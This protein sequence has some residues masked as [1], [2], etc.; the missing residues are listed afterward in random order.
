MADCFWTDL[1]NTS[2]EPTPAPPAPATGDLYVTGSNADGA[3]GIPA[4][5]DLDVFT[6][7]TGE[8]VISDI[9]SGGGFHLL[10]K[11]GVV[12]GVGVSYDDQLNDG[13]F[14]TVNDY[15]DVYNGA[16][17]ISAGA[18]VSGILTTANNLIYY[19]GQSNKFDPPGGIEENGSWSSIHAGR[20][21][22]FAISNGGDLYVRGG[23]DKAGSGGVFHNSLTQVNTGFTKVSSSSGSI[24]HTLAITSGGDL[25]ATGDNT[26]GQLG[27]GDNTNRNVFTL[28]G[29]GYSD[30]VAGGNHS[31]ALKPNGDL[32]V[33]GRNNNGQLGLNN[34]VDQNSFVLAETGVVSLAK[35]LDG[36]VS[37]V[38]KSNGDLYATGLNTSGQLGLGDT[39]QRQVFTLVGTGFIAVSNADTSTIALK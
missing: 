5:P 21:I 24:G 9:S 4:S 10:L 12:R 17:Q 1:N 31:L 8:T 15:L 33:C 18:T 28:V 23:G 25:Y 3:L 19:G 29:G 22:V 30:F 39:T 14:D 13:S 35:S 36:N 2:C 11:S 6:A 38:L 7:V 34:L 20:D 32:F 16:S 26:Y 37:F 27:L